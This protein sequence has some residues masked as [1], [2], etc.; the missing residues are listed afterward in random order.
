MNKLSKFLM[1]LGVVFAFASSTSCAEI[2]LLSGS[3]SESSSE[4]LNSESTEQVSTPTETESEVSESQ[5]DTTTD[6]STDDGNPDASIKDNFDCI[7]I[8]EAIEIALAS[9]KQESQKYYVYGTVKSVSNPIYGEMTITDGTDSLYVYGTYSA[10]GKLRYSEL[11]DKPVAG[12]EVV[13]YGGLKT[14]NDEPEM[15]SAWIQAFNHIIPDVDDYEAVT[16][17]QAREAEKDSKVKI[18]GTVAQITYANGY[19]P[20]GVYLVDETSSIYVYSS[21]VAGQVKVGNTITVAGNKTYYVLEK[22]QQAAAKWGYE[23]SCQLDSATLI[24][25]DKAVTDFNT[26]WIEEKSIKE[27]MESPFTTNITNEIYKV[28]AFIKKAP[29]NGFTNYYFNDYDGTT[30]SYVYTQC[31]G[32]DFEWLDVYDGKLCTLYM[33][34]INA[35]AT[36]ASCIYRFIP[37]K[38]ISDNATFDVSESAQFVLDYYITKQFTSTTFRAN[39]EIELKTSVSVETINIENAT[40]SYSSSDESLVYI[41]NENGKTILNTSTENYGNATLTITVTVGQYTAT[42]EIEFTVLE[43][44]DLDSLAGVKEVF[45]A[46]DETEMTVIGIAGPSLVNQMG[47]YLIDEDGILAIKCTEATMALINLGD[48]VIMKGTRVHYNPEGVIGQTT[49]LDSVLVENLYGGHEYSTASFDSTKTVS[50]LYSLSVQEDYTTKAY[51][52]DVTV[53]VVEA[54]YYTN[55]YLHDPENYEKSVRLYC[56]SA[57]Q[58]AWLKQYAGKTITVEIA[59]CNWNYK[60]YYATCLLA[61]INED[62]SKTYNELNYESA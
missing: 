18:T 23:G 49:L 1:S 8:K 43:Q 27:I 31:N 58:Y 38:V 41:T 9:G 25:N 59:V 24:S 11:E 52:L 62:G 40:V 60:A 54:A 30:G 2:P 14:Y 48:Q 36:A 53:E 57:N 42:T 51:I 34:A 7:T 4:V 50:D 5:T 45:E 22:E 26:S 56:S 47:F 61:V 37:I 10:D 44:I 33:T 20:S 29:G 35:K 17:K 39:P 3:N 55:I 32:G 15:G 28:N 6:S 19:V 16:I 46:A 21:D 12:D 13:L